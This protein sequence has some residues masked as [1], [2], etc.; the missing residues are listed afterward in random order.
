MIRAPRARP[1]PGR[2][3]GE[4]GAAGGSDLRGDVARFLRVRERTRR[5]VADY[6]A[7]RGHPAAEITQAISELVGA[8]W[9]DDRRFA[10][11]YLRDRRRLHPVGRAEILRQL[12]A[13][14]IE[15]ALAEEVLAGCEPAWNDEDLAS[16]ALARRWPRWRA[17]ERVARAHR[18]LRGRGFG[19]AAVRT[20][21]AR[22]EGRA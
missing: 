8:G 5:E 18:F 14:G 11:V 4:S 19:G 10:E 6:L 1:Q 20:A 3:P 2:E 16:A 22:A 12:R 9:I 17:E 15:P 21:I 13:R 7:R